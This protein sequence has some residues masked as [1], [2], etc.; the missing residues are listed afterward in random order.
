MR[1]TDGSVYQ[2]EWK[3][4]IQ[5]GQGKMVF[6]DGTVK[7]GYF[8]NNVFKGKGPIINEVILEDTN[9]DLQQTMQ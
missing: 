9:E 5:H 7:E 3:R 4:G 8:E 1:W 2:G 6:A